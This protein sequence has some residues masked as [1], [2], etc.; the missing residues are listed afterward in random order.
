[1]KILAVLVTLLLL[2]QCAAFKSEGLDVQLN[3][4]KHQGAFT[5]PCIRTDEY[6]R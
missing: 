5:L 6:A 1:M 2:Q 3:F 4:I